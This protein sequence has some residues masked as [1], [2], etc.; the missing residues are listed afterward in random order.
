MTWKGDALVWDV[1]AG[2]LVARLPV[3]WTSDVVDFSPDGSTL[4][5]GFRRR[6]SSGTSKATSASS[7]R[8]ARPRQRLRLDRPR[9]RGRLRR[10]PS[11]GPHLLQHSLWHLGEH[12]ERHTGY[13]SA[14]GKLASRRCP[15]RVGQRG[16][17]AVWNAS[18]D[19]LTIGR[20][21]SGR[22]VTSTDYSAD[23]SRI[24]IGELSGQVTMLD[25]AT[26]EPVG[27][28][29]RLD[30]AVCCV[31]AG[32][33]NRT[34]LVLTGYYDPSG[35]RLGASTRW[36]LVDLES[37]TVVHE[38]DVGFNGVAPAMS[39]DGANAA[40]GGHDGELLLVDTVTGEP[41]TA[42]VVG[43]DKIFTLTYSADGTRVLT[44]A[45]DG[46]VSL[47]DA[48]TG[49]Q[50]AR[51]VSPIPTAVAE[52][53][54]DPNTIRIAAWDSGPIYEWDP[55]ISTAVDFACE[56]AGRD[57][58]EAEWHQTFGDRPYQETCPSS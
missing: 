49:E 32:P 16:R 33:D 40:I 31:A 38:G 23:G 5:T 21:P 54:Q 1:V 14:R 44:S 48:S 22:Y 4:Y 53:G 42:P 51:L 47:L 24:V 3:G 57:L 56:V 58:T 19:Q 11:W 26:L 41:L 37:G 8:W 43:R 46:S 9:T 13:S 29:F 34:A 6:S 35:F 2:R 10:L 28:P 55:R 50:L 18:T 30:D 15:L 27:Q 39:P 12:L 7:H 20:R 25:A 45:G 17:G 36:S 52:F